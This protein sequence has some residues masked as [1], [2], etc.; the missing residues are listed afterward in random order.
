MQRL[1]DL[2]I[3]TASRWN[4]NSS[5]L[6]PDPGCFSCSHGGLDWVS[7]GHRPYWADD[8]DQNSTKR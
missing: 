7:S 8:A 3:C 6:I 4:L 2:P 1:S 5:L